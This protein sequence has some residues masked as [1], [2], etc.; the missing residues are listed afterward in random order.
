MSVEKI[1]Q[2]KANKC[3]EMINTLL[4]SSSFSSIIIGNENSAVKL[5]NN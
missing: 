2:K 4:K 3:E 1:K 5:F